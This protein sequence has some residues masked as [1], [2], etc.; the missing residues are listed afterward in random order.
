[1]AANNPKATMTKAKV[2]NFL[3]SERLFDKP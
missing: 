3:F 2:D 1:M